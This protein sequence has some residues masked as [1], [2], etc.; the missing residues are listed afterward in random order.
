MIVNLGARPDGG[1]RKHKQFRPELFIKDSSFDQSEAT[2]T[3]VA[4]PDSAGPQVTVCFEGLF[5]LSIFYRQYFRAMRSMA[6][7]LRSTSKSVV[8]QDD[9]LIRIAVRPCQTVAPHQQVPSV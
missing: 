7:K 5:G 2:K 8:A 1:D 9:T 3:T 6:S 4:R